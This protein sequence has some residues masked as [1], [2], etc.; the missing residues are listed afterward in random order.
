MPLIVNESYQIIARST[1]SDGIQETFLGRFVAYSRAGPVFNTLE[2]DSQRLTF[3]LT[4][5]VIIKWN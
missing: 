4:K 5:F 1:N 3:P 2:I